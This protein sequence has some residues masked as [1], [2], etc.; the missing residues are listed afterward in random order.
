MGNN[1]SYISRSSASSA[2]GTSVQPTVPGSV[3]NGNLL[4]AL[5]QGL[6][7]VDTTS[8]G[9]EFLGRSGNNYHGLFAKYYAGESGPYTFTQNT[10]SFLRATVVNYSG[11]FPAIANLSNVF[12]N[13]DYTTPGTV[14]V[15]ADMT[16]TETDLDIIWIAGCYRTSATTF[17]TIPTS[18]G[19]FTKDFEDGDTTAYMWQ[20]FARYT[21]SSSG[22]TGDMI[23]SLSG[24]VSGGKHAFAIALNPPSGVVNGMMMIGF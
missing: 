21:W 15:A 18:P 17:P 14:V 8:S 10:S 20:T 6:G 23:G 7:Q 19:T 2:S 9:W 22:A 5:V 11:N 1:L 13:T 24:S 4:L 12:S 16:T 3:S